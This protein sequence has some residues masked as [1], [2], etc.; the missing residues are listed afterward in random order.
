[1]KQPKAVKAWAIYRVRTGKVW[2]ILTTTSLAKFASGPGDGI[3]EGAFFPH[4][5]I[6]PI[7]KKRRG[8]KR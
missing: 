7:V 5:N 3:V 4:T 6:A 1:M 8:K 2:A